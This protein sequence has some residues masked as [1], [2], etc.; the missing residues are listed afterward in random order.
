[1]QTHCGKLKKR[2]LGFTQLSSDTGIGSR[3]HSLGLLLGSHCKG[4]P[5]AWSW[6][7]YDGMLA[8]SL[9]NI[10]VAPFGAS[11]VPIISP[12]VRAGPSVMTVAATSLLWVVFTP[13][14]LLYGDQKPTQ[15]LS[16][17]KGTGNQRECSP[18]CGL[19]RDWQ[20]LDCDRAPRLV[21]GSGSK[22][23][24]SGGTKMGVAPRGQERDSLSS[25][26]P[27]FLVSWLVV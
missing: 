2:P 1:M 4:S 23:S 26:Q 18:L 21:R 6:V 16:A 25:W 17:G 22:M 10:C 3:S 8:P 27:L 24:W 15:I 19:N 11:P 13:T 20:T 12:S 5:Q 14:C 7:V 9:S